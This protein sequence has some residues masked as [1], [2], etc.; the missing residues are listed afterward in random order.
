VELV[1]TPLF[2]ASARRLLTEEDRRDLEVFL[3]TDPS[4]GA[5]IPRTG[6]L[7][8]VRFSRGSRSEG[9]RGGMRVIYYFVQRRSC[10]YLI[11][12]YSKRSKDNLTR[13]EEIGLRAVARVL[14]GEGL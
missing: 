14:R 5:L 3:A 8:K 7:R 4:R 11:D 12:V 2:E 6:G 9:T 10:I 1:S 13:A